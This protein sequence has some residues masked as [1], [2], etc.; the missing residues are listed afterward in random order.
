MC[1]ARLSETVQVLVDGEFT[2]RDRPLGYDPVFDEF[3]AAGQHHGE[4]VTHCPWCGT[5]L[6]PGRRDAWFRRLDELGLTPNDDLPVDLLSD[7]WW[8]P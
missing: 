4:P 8:R 3:R 7:A 5:D 1:C 6:G 2:S